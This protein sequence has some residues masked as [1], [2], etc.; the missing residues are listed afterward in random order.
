MLDL[1]QEPIEVFVGESHYCTQMTGAKR[2]L[3]EKRDSFQYVPLLDSLSVLLKDETVLECIDNPHNRS[4]GWL[5]DYCDGELVSLHP[6]FSDLRSIQIV[7]YYDEL[8]VCN[9]LGT[10]TKKHKLGIIIYTGKH[11][12]QV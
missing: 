11:P 6:I 4:D 10:H 1:L 8:E 2:R 7:A 5:E 3:V 12:T 9:P